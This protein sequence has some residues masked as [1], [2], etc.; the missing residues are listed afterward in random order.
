M[1]ARQGNKYVYL[2]QEFSIPLLLG[3]VVAL[4]FANVNNPLYEQIVHHTTTLFVPEDDNQHGGSAAGE[5][6]EDG[7]DH[8]TDSVEGDGQDI[9]TGEDHGDSHGGWRHFLSLHFI[10][11]D[12]FMVLFFGV[13]AKEITESCLPGGAL[14][15]PSKAINPLLGTL[16]GVVG[17]VCVYVLLNL[18]IG[19]QTLPG[20]KNGWGNGWG[21]PTA[22][23]IALAWLIA[24]IVFGTGHPA[25]SFLLL[26]AVADDGIGLLII[27]F[28]YPKLTPEWIN[29]LWIV[30]GVGV[31]FGLRT[32]KVQNWIPYIAIGGALSWWGLFSTHLHPAL[33]LV[34][35]VP[36]LPGPK[37]DEGLFRDD[38][39]TIE[40]DPLNKFEHS[41]K[42]LVDFGLFFFAF[43]NAGV[44]FESMSN[45]TWIV[46]LSL[47][48]GKTAGI[49]LF[50]W[51]GI[52]A[53]CPLPD[54]MN[55][56]HLFVAGIVA[57]LG[58][59]VALFVAGEAFKINLE[60]QGAAKMGALF[61]GGVALLAIIV[62]RLLGVKDGGGTT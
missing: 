25:I 37:Y 56:K 43:C 57:A 40:T 6:I 53:G 26:L 49:T 20:N 47:L 23:D 28:F 15:P 7:H 27:A 44:A 2:L 54:G 8:S 3:V 52:L 60:W 61:S 21:I 19:D 31:A 62:G 32:M 1:S 55:I 39:K 59:T 51:L 58:L 5:S 42:V 10:I 13:A 41:V 48:L 17:P 46:L 16:G 50:S 12:V 35:I 14:N 22:T 34:P 4:I 45:L 38:P 33:A 24:R 11:N 29:V 30:A 36:L 9:H 18:L